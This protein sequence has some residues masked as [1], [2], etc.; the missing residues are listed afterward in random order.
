MHQYGRAKDGTKGYQGLYE[1]Y[2][3]NI[4]ARRSWYGAQVI[5]WNILCRIYY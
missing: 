2:I 4:A 5:G 1:R 3:V